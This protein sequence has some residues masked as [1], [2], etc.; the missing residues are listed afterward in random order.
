MSYLRHLLVFSCSLLL[1]SCLAELELREISVTDEAV[2]LDDSALLEDM[3]LLEDM[4]PPE[5]MTPLTDT[6]MPIVDMEANC[7]VSYEICDG[8]D[9]D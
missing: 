5:D 7:E 3:T 6:I 4:A 1:S 2:P 9:N 8:T